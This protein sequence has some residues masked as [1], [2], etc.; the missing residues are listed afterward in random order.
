[1]VVWGDRDTVVPVEKS[2]AIIERL[3]TKA[4]NKQITL[5][6]LPGVDHGNN[7]V[8]H[9]DAWDFPRVEAEYFR[10]IVQWTKKTVT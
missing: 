3:Q 6:V 1:L 8:R 4:G 10:T 2:R 5:K 7:I 9:G